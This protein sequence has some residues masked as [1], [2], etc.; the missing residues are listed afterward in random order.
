MRVFRKIRSLVKKARF[1]ILV[2]SVIGGAHQAKAVD[3]ADYGVQASVAREAQCVQKRIPAGVSSLVARE[4]WQPLTLVPGAGCSRPRVLLS[5]ADASLAQR[6]FLTAVASCTG[7]Q[8]VDD[9][10]GNL[11]TLAQAT[12]ILT[13][14]GIQD[15]M[16]GRSLLATLFE[17][18]RVCNPT[19]NKKDL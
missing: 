16:T 14:S 11:A 5:D 7:K 19:N 18:E 2:A 1:L 12:A 4:M 6:A 13:A 3:L 9:A 10:E 8:P 17:G 15:A